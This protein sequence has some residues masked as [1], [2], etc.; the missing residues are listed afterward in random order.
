MIA[1]FLALPISTLPTLTTA[2]GWLISTNPTEIRAKSSVCRIAAFAFST[3]PL[4]SFGTMGAKSRRP[5]PPEIRAAG[6]STASFF[7]FAGH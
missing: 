4:L 1:S 5:E 6:R 7:T 3:Y 2:L